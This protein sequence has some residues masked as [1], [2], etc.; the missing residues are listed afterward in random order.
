MTKP[1]TITLGQ[2]RREVLS[3]LEKEPDS[4]KI[5][6]GNGDLMFYRPKWRGDYFTIEFNQVYQVTADPD[7]DPKV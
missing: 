1:Y 7:A 4:T 3:Q 5:Y 6:F 2:F